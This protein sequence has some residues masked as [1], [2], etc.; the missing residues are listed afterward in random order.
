VLPVVHVEYALS[1][2][3][4]FADVVAS[5]ANAELAYDG[6]LLG[7]ARWFSSTDGAALVGHLQ[8]RTRSR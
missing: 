5:P 7:H 1:E 2:I 8:A 4:Y 6:Y 3:E